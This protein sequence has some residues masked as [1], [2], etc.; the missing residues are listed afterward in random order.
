M[1]KKVIQDHVDEIN[2]IIYD[3]LLHS[4]DYNAELSEA[5]SYAV[6]AGGK[7]LRPMLMLETYRM[8]AEGRPEP[9]ILYALMA[10]IEF[11]HTYSLIHDDLPAMDDDD[12]RRGQLTVHRKYGEAAGILTGDALLNKAY[13]VIFDAIDGSGEPDDYMGGISAARVIALKAGMSG[14]VGGQYVDV[15]SEK[16]ADFSVDG[17]CLN[18]IYKNKTSALIEAAMMSGAI[19][20]GAEDI[21]VDLVEKMA[22]YLGMAFQIRDDILDISGDQALLGKPVGSDEKNDK[23]TYVSIY[24]YDNAVK[25]VGEYTSRAL[26]IFDSLRHK[27]NFLR[28]LIIELIEREK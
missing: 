9:E 2:S 15:Y 19:L 24:G 13:E 12:Y 22:G 20:G 14:M 8:F 26:E 7:R 3:Y 21:E 27:N 18:Y 23:Q 16:H 4:D 11:I 17:K 6:K 25:A 28:D 5:M 10:A 1:D